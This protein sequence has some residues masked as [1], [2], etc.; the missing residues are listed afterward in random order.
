M[1]LSLSAIVSTL[2]SV[3]DT[4]TAAATPIESSG[5]GFFTSQL[6][7]SILVLL[8][9]FHMLLGLA[10]GGTYLERKI[11]AYIQD[12]IGPNRV[13]LD[14]GLPLLKWFKGLF[15][16]G[17][18]LADGIK[19]ILKEDYTPRGADKTLFTLAATIVVIPAIMGFAVLPWGGQVSIPAWTLPV[20]D[21]HVPAQV[22]TVAGANINIGIIYL[23]ATASLG[24]YAVTLAGWAS[25]NKYSFL[26]GL[27][28]SAQMISYEIP[29]GLSIL[30]V[31]LLTGSLIPMTIVKHQ[32]A[33]GWLILSQPVM[34]AMFFICMLA[35]SNRTPF[36]NAECEQELVG[37]YH[38]EYSAMRMALFLLTEYIHFTT[39]AAFFVLMFL[40]GFHLPLNW[41][42]MDTH[43]L[44]AHD[45][46]VLGAILKFHV[47][48]FK[49]LLVVFVIMLVRWTIPRLKYDQVM[50]IA[51][52]G[53]IPLALVIVI[54]TSIMVHTERT[55]T[56]AML[57]FNAALLGVICLFITD[58]PRAT[59]NKKIRLAGSRFFPLEGE[60]VITRPTSPD[61]L[62]DDPK[63]GAAAMT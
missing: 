26:G 5:P 52:Q 38:T 57:L 55:G 27:R 60:R 17:Q 46:S 39:G 49:V 13:G 3:S 63:A 30:C 42:G 58:L 12:R 23:L 29:M 14:F 36:D 33:H 16:L 35:E 41:L 32:E 9:V 44:S 19:F 34:A 11:S 22:V 21:W 20:L 59:S 45:T 50:S 4:A 7:V 61:A 8:I 62:A 37:G 51:W 1:I 40:G 15:G 48:V 10:G 18:P 56:L 54:G 25:N 24:I 6:L 43:L 47:F 31:L 53:M 2:A 28:S